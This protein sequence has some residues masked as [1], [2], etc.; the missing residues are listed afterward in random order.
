M[1]GWLQAVPVGIREFR[2]KGDCEARGLS[3]RVIEE[4]R[5]S[6]ESVTKVVGGRLDTACSLSRMTL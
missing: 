2:N 1:F 5:K 4:S 3:K 6:H